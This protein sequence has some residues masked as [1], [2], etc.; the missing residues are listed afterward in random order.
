MFTHIPFQLKVKQ[1]LL[2]TSVEDCTSFRSLD[3]DGGV[4]ALTSLVMFRSSACRTGQQPELNIRI[5]NQPVQLELV[6]IIASI[7]T[8]NSFLF[9]PA[10]PRGPC[11]R[12]SLNMTERESP[13]P[14]LCVWHHWQF[15]NGQTV[16]REGLIRSRLRQPLP[17]H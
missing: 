4:S 5:Q 1:F 8:R 17:V 13:F 11:S 14:Y 6:D 9:F 10:K 15:P 16:A 7:Y 2:N 12:Q 3:E